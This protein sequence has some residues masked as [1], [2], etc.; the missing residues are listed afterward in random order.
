MI[1]LD[2]LRKRIPLPTTRGPTVA[3]EDLNRISYFCFGE[4]VSA[5]FS[6]TG[7]GFES[8][9]RYDHDIEISAQIIQ[10]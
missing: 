5:G 8:P 10:P 3:F 6:A 9:Y 4:P 1:F 2:T 7:P